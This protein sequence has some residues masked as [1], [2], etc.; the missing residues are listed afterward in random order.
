MSTQILEGYSSAEK[1]AYITA[2]ASIATADQSA[3][4]QEVNYIGN[5]ADA[6]GLNDNE[7]QQ[8]FTAA[9][10]TSG[11]PLKSA[12]DTLKASELKYSLVADLIAFAEADSNVAEQEKQHIASIAKY[13]EIN[14]DQLQALNEYVKEAAAQ[15][16]DAM[17]I[18]GGGSN[19]SGAGGILENLGLGQ[20]LQNSGIN[21]GSL[22]KGLISFVGPM[23]MGN[24]LNKGMQNKGATAG[25]N[26]SG[27]LGSL[28]GSL[29]GGKGFG[30]IGGFLTNLLK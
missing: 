17:G 23:I 15:P 3:S 30:G 7:K 12:L 9:R 27:G 10:D 25:L 28:I 8:V 24:M 5:L 1:A 21:I 11:A 19:A 14:A 26:Q 16:A 22:A 29:S 18:F 4:D 13:L 2:I 6:A 20:K